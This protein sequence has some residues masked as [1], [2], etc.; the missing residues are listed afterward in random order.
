MSA[1]AVQTELKKS[2]EVTPSTFQAKRGRK[3]ANKQ[4]ETKDMT[5]VVENLKVTKTVFD[6]QKFDDVKL[7]KEVPAPAK[8]GSLKEASEMLN[9]DT[10]KLL[11]IIYAGLVEDARENAQKDMSGFKVYDE[12]K[13]EKDFETYNGTFADEEKGK[14]INAAVLSLAKM[15]GYEKGKSREE[16]AAL[17][18]KAR[19]FLRSTPAML[20]S[21]QK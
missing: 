16:K 21:I 20:A 5:P 17:K 1:I 2:Q 11:N 12:D 6:L 15:Q 19:E 8:P 13:E 10:E 3:V 14:L 18:E 9:N 4:E 7:V